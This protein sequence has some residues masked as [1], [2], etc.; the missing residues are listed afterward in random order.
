MRLHILSDIHLEFEPF[1]PPEVEADIVILA[2]DIHL[3]SKGLAWAKERFRSGP[4]IYV[5]GNHEYYGTALPKHTAAL[6]A[7]AK[8]GNIHVLETDV[9]ELGGVT[10]LGCTLWTDF[11]VFGDPR[12]AG[13]MATQQMTDYRRIRVSPSY[14]KLRSID[15]AVLHRRSVRWLEEELRAR[16]GERMVVVTHHAPSLRSV[17]EGLRENILSAAYASNLERLVAESGAALWIHGHIHAASD[18]VIGETRVVCN[19]RGY[20]DE[21]NT[22]FIDDWTLEV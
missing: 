13:Y 12:I 22:G 3:K 8:G 10:F 1:D 16:R 14:R 9:L 18:Y 17:P 2:G 11:E 4:V 20:P 5:M 21:V 7:E 6:K 15:T 19:P